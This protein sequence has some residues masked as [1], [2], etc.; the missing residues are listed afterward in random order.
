MLLMPPMKPIEELNSLLALVSDINLILAKHG[1]GQEI[2]LSDLTVTTA[3]V[4]D[5]LKPIPRLSDAITD[6]L[7]PSLGSATLYHYTSREAAESILSTGT[8]RLHCIAKRCNEGEISTFCESHKLAGYL[9]KDNSGEPLYKS[10]LMPNTFYASF[11]DSNITP[12]REDYFWRTFAPCDGVRLKVGISAS[13]PDLRRVRY[14]PSAGQP[15]ELLSELADV[16]RDKHQRALILK[17]ISRLCSFYLSG[18]DYGKENEVRLLFRAS[19]GFGPQPIND[20][21]WS[22]VELPLGLMTE[23]GYRLD[24]TE[25]HARERPC[26]PSQYAFSKRVA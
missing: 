14:E 16:V 2:S 3:T 8:F 18:E 20:G 13:N 6:F 21:R 1:V 11:T 5:L 10:L 15:I 7:W 23:C 4:S 12:E 19:D 25:V 24:V 22:Y 9:E 17:G 26:I